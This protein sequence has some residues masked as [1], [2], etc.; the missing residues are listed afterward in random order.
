VRDRFDIICFCEEVTYG[1]IIDAIDNG[2]D[3]IVKLGDAVMSG[4]TCGYCIEDLEEILEEEL[5]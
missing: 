2:A 1:D 4:I 3:T 5:N